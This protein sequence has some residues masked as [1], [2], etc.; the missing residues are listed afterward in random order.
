VVNGLAQQ[1]VNGVMLGAVYVTVAVA[2]T[3]TIGILDFLN[4]T[5]PGLFMLTGMLA[6]GVLSAG[7]FSA[8][9]SLAWVP[10]LLIGGAGSIIVSLLV[11]RFAYRYL[12][13]RFGDA[14]EHAIPIVSSLGFLLVIENLV[15]IYLGTD[16]Q[17]FPTR[18]GGASIR[19]AGLLVSL[20]QLVSLILAIV[21]VASLTLLVR[22]SRVGRALRAIAENRD[23][24]AI[25]GIDVSRIV[26][27]VFA[28]TGLLC[29]IAGSIYAVN[30][31]QVSST[32]GDDVGVKAIAGMV[33][34][35]LGSI[36]G[37]VAGGLAVGL[38][39][40]LSIQ[41][42]GTDSVTAVVWGLLLLVLLIWP[43]GL[44]GSNRVGRGKL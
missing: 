41:F 29:A 18:F 33:I 26:P 16:T 23:A 34:G 13:A 2:F 32:M 44:F 3:L 37:A 22:R 15:G 25:V 4:F 28:I 19:V 20:P 14:S 6:W 43:K 31:G 35:G 40:S 30:Y 8:M 27:V 12:K 42:L 36:W 1:L 39:E 7:W 11:E 10:S 17:A 24:A 21:L 5:I 38:A 9:G